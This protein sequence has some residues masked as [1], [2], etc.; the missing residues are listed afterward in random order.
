MDVGIRSAAHGVDILSLPAEICILLG[1]RLD[2]KSLGCLVRV[3]RGLE[4]VFTPI[5]YAKWYSDFLLN[6]PDLPE[7]PPLPS[8]ISFAKELEVVIDGEFHDLDEH[9]R[10][11]DPYDE[12]VQ[13]NLEERLV[14]LR[15]SCTDYISRMVEL[16]SSIQILKYARYL[17]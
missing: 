7:F 16:A 15:K 12:G 14:R 5:L 10:D 3:C 9:N 6:G 2:V 11:R 4:D 13:A 17:L 1:E 8:N